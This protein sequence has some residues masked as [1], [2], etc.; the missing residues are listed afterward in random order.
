MSACLVSLYLIVVVACLPFDCFRS[1][2]LFV[3]LFGILRDL[4]CG[5]C[6]V[7]FVGLFCGLLDVG[8]GL[9]L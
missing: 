8:C 6:V 1:R 3:W 7:L 9:V 4:I 5:L 2:L